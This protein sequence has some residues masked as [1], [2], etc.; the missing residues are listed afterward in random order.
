M[1]WFTKIYFFT[2]FIH[3]SSRFRVRDLL[4]LPKSKEISSTNLGFRKYFW[5]IRIG[6]LS[7]L[8]L[9]LQKNGDTQLQN[10]DF[11]KNFFFFFNLEIYSFTIL[12]F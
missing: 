5:D 11:R 10:T 3:P 4:Q 2:I 8:F 1:Y 12:K 9:I 6:K 7:I